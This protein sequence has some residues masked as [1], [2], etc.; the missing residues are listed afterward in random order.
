MSI[1]ISKDH[2]IYHI[3]DRQ[4]HQG[5]DCNPY[6]LIDG[7]EAVLFDPGNCFDV[8][9][10]YENIVALIPASAVK[11]IVLHHQDPDFCSAV[12]LLE[13]KGIHAK[14]IT[15][16]R[17]QTLIQYYGIQSEFKLIEELGNKLELASGRTLRFI[18]TPYLHFAGAF[19]TYDPKSTTLFS[20]DLFGAY[21]YNNALYADD[22]YIEKMETFHEHYMPSNAVLRPV[23]ELLSKYDIQLICPQHGSI[24]NSDIQT[25]IDVLK[26]LECG[27]LMSPIKKRDRKS[28]V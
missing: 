28:V 3:G 7:D 27:T 2:L 14:I 12:P 25:Y 21:S 24:I 4:T 23:M 5:L 26:N 11:Y 13:A 6:L 20:S 10:V 9:A 15:S 19:V 16:W 17:A 8:E 22:Q 18:L 1:L